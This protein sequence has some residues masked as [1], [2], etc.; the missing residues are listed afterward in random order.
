MYYKNYPSWNEVKEDL[1]Q[2]DLLEIIEAAQDLGLDEA[3]QEYIEASYEP[4]Y[5][6]DADALRDAYLEEVA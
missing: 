5:E 6:V 4:S 2:N 1:S 3:I